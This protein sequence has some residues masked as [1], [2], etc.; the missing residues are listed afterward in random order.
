[1]KLIYCL[2]VFSLL[3]FSGF[4]QEATMSSGG[5]GGFT[6][7]YGYM[8]L[9]P[10]KNFLPADYPSLSSDHMLLGGMGYG[11]TNRFVI[12]GGGSALIGNGYSN[13]S[14]SVSS[15]GGM[16]TFNFGYIIVDKEKMKIFPMLGLGGGGYGL[17]ITNNS[18][19][20]IDDIQT[21]SAQEINISK[22]SFLLDL[23][24]HMDFVPGL[25]Y[26]KEENSYGGFMTGLQ[27]GYTMGFPDSKW[28]Y[29]GGNINGGPNFG[30]S[31]LYVKLI[32]GGLGY[33]R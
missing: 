18:N 5:A 1:M 17:T 30:V 16:G 2:S 8:D 28:S 15:G 3:S 31:M 4:S 6:I 33:E 7:G 23:A 10:L 22:G 21:R 9:S 13:D 19:I 27:I 20:S 32:V 14:V 11:F 12:G 25:Q 29:A 24:I 26:D